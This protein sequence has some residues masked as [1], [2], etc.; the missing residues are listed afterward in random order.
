[1]SIMVFGIAA[2]LLLASIMAF[3]L[4][5]R[6]DNI[7]TRHTYYMCVFGG[8]FCSIATFGAAFFTKC[9]LYM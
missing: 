6:K 7:D 5:R 4:A 1:M 8:I 2:I 9:C 3:L